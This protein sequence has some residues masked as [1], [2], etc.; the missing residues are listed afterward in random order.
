M[1]LTHWHLAL[2]EHVT[3]LYSILSVLQHLFEVV[4]L[5]I[6]PFIRLSVQTQFFPSNE[7]EQN[8]SAFDSWNAHLRLNAGQG[9]LDLRWRRQIQITA[10]RMYAFSGL[11]CQTSF[12]SGPQNRTEMR[13]SSWKGKVSLMR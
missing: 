2:S 5:R 4:R 11:S 3:Y 1:Y 7:T 12:N 9:Y 6:Q 13:I 8:V 10:Q